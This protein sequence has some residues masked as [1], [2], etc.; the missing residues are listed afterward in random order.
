M[1]LP[2]LE[3]P[4]SDRYFASGEVT[5]AADVVIAPG[6][7]L[8][9]EADSRIEIASG[10]CIGLGSVL[11]ARGGAIIIQAGALLAAGV[12][13]V[14]Q[15]VVGRQACLG[16]STTLMDV[17]VEAGGVTAPGSLL[18]AQAT[19]SAPTA[20]SAASASVPASEVRSSQ[21]SAIAQPTKVYGKEQF[22]RMRQSMFPDR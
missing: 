18:S 21:A 8:I 17:S 11:H 10:V 9:A 14:G 2:P 16:P 13:I 7:L 22:L 5:I 15:S 4:I 3:P 19:G 20:A 1:H 12:L 6:V